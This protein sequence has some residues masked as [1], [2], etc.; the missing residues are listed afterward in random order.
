MAAVSLDFVSSGAAF[1]AADERKRMLANGIRFGS[2]DRE[3]GLEKVRI[4]GA[5]VSQFAENGAA[6]ARQIA[7]RY[8]DETSKIPAEI[9]ADHV[10]R[11]SQRE[12]LFMAARELEGAA[13][14]R[15]PMGFDTLSGEAK[16]LLA[17]F[18]DFG[19]VARDRF[20]RALVAAST[21]LAPVATQAARVR[22]D[23]AQSPSGSSPS[24]SLFDTYPDAQR[25]AGGLDD[26][27]AARR[28]RRRI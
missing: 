27:K 3:A 8:E 19:G 25:G 18:L 26:R 4:A 2:V 20:A 10:S 15:A 11:I 9:I 23:A 21:R 13:H 6:L 1:R 28:K 14:S 24:G 17:A 12:T 22:A 7:N 16:S 5:L